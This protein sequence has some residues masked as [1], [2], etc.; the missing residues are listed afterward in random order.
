VPRRNI[1]EEN[2]HQVGHEKAKPRSQ[3]DDQPKREQTTTIEGFGFV[4]SR[5]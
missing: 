1:S 4:I 3:R 5:L 2:R